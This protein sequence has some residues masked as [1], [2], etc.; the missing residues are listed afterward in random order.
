MTPPTTLLYVNAVGQDGWVNGRADDGAFIP[1]CKYTKVSIAE[2]KG[3]RTYFE[4]LDGARRG[5]KL[6]MSDGNASTYLG[7]KAPSKGAAKITVKYG[8]YV[9][10]WYSA[11]RKLSLNQRLATLSVEGRQADVTMNTN[12]G[13]GYYP[14]PAGTY[15]VG[16]PDAPHAGDMTN[17]YRTVAPA[18][19]HDQVWFPI[20]YGDKS[21][22]VHVGNI[23][24]GCVT[25][26]SLE[27]WPGICEALISHRSEDGAYVATLV[28]VGKPER[29]R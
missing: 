25:V 1:L 15:N 23:S 8:R 18:L 3:G 12:W 5:A 13:V 4:V 24:D 2:R 28:V 29:A 6:S 27:Q 17:Y 26:I 9:E 7:P 19:I 10:G 11:A 16:T 14:L 22:Y 20:Q 21:R